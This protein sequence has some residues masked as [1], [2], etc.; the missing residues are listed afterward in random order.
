MR[1]K[2]LSGQLRLVKITLSQSD[3][4]NIEFT[5]LP[6][7]HVLHLLIKQINLCIGNRSAN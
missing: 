2:A 1:N 7:W 6:N 4:P 3:S 5:R